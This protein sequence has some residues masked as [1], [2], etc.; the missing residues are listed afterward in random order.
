LNKN[1]EEE[2][3]EEKDWK[4]GEKHGKMKAKK[5]AMIETEGG[6]FVSPTEKDGRTYGHLDGGI[7]VEPLK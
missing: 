6:K 2:V 1:P 3:E 4:K 7:F 5:W